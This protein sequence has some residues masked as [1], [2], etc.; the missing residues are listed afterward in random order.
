LK[1]PEIFINMM[2]LNCKGKLLPLDKPV[3][4]GIINLT[5]DSFYSGSRMSNSQAVKLKIA[6]MIEEGAQIID[7]GAQSTRPGSVPVLPTGEIEKLLPVIEWL[8]N[9]YP[10]IIISV[11][12]YYAEVASGVARAGAHIIND[13]SGGNL[14]ED[15]IDTVAAL[16]LPY[17]CMHMRG[18][19]QTMQQLTEYEDVTLSVLD[20]FIEK[21]AACHK[22]GI[23]DVI[24]DPGFGFA[25]TIGQNFQLLKNMYLLKIAGKPLL[26]GL[27]RKSTIYRTLGITPE[28][29]LNGTT[30]LHM[31]ALQ[32]GANILRVHDVKEAVQAITLW[33]HYSHA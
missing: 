22:A 11:D 19:P 3:V 8:R 13:I 28:E 10:E 17:I 12:T 26:A 24:L 1:T 25:K 32:Q 15:M 29:S 18:N 30:A 9:S 5:T 4:M 14:D 21:T 20:Y 33:E 7:I 23:T 6:Q 16:H 2:S 27:S 31:L